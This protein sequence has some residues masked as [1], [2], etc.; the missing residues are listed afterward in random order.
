MFLVFG[1]WF[2]V[3]GFWFLVFGFWFLDFGLGFEGLRLKFVVYSLGFRGFWSPVL[4][5]VCKRVKAG[6]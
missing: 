4:C 3:F 2:S 1:F 5:G 6:E